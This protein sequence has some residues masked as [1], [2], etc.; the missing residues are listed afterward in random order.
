MTSNARLTTRGL[1]PQAE[2]I[3]KQINLA[4]EVLTDATKR[5]QYDAGTDFADLVVGFWDGL[6][7]RMQV[8]MSGFHPWPAKHAC[9]SLARHLLLRRARAQ[10]S[11]RA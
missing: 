7:R 10:C 5:R 9:P 8:R 1:R 11:R 4:N 2:L 3:F 6:V